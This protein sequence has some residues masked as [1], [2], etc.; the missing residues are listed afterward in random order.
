[1][2]PNDYDRIEKAILFL[3]SNFRSQPT[4]Q[5][6]AASVDLSEYHFQRLFRRWAG[7]SPKRFTEYLTATFAEGLLRQSR[8]VL[9]AAYEAGL[10]ST[11]RLHDLFVNFYGV[12]PGAV[13][14]FGAGLTIRFG[15][16]PSPFGPCLVAVTERG[17]CGLTFLSFE[18]KSAALADLARRWPAATIREAPAATRPLAEKIFATGVGAADPPIDLYVRGTRFQIQVWEA[19]L[20]IPP[21]SVASYEAV[22]ERIGAPTAARAVGAAVAQN[23]V[24]FLIPCHRVIRKSGVI[25]PYRWGAARKKAILGWEAARA[26]PEENA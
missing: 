17:L 6:I 8:S 24:A 18:G 21:G 1:M 22:A 4:L 12:T 15:V 13:K 10:S 14:A 20:R 3:E 25:G 9:D 19:L 26:D 5:E 11:G 23:P 16:H 7:I 2:P